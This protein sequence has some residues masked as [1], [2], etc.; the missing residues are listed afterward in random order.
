MVYLAVEQRGVVLGIADV[1]VLERELVLAYLDGVAEVVRRVQEIDF[2]LTVI[3]HDVAF[4]EDFLQRAEDSQFARGVARDIGHHAVEVFLYEVELERRHIG[5]EFQRVVLREVLAFYHN[6]RVAYAVTQKS[7]Q[8][9]VGIAIGLLPALEHMPLG[10]QPSG[11]AVP[12]ALQVHVA[13]HGV[14]ERE[15]VGGGVD[16]QHHRSEQSIDTSL[17]VNHSVQVNSVNSDKVH[18]I[19]QAHTAQ[20]HINTV[21]HVL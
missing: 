18:Y 19:S 21:G 4:H 16:I 1:N 10:M 7:S 15:V 17:T 11:L 9:S 14:V 8:E 3:H 2:K 13:P 6:G 12:L 5:K 20:V